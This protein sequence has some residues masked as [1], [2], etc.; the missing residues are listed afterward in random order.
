MK[1]SDLKKFSSELR[2]CVKKSKIHPNDVKKIWHMDNGKIKRKKKFRDP[3]EKDWDNKY[4]E[5]W[6]K[7]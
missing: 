6:D 3:I 7:V 5:Y 4:D 2:G 1:K